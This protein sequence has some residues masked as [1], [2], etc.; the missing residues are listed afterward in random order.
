MTARA[1]SKYGPARRAAAG[2]ALAWLA[3]GACERPPAAS[4]DARPLVVTTTTMITDL[5]RQLAGDRVRVVGVIPPGMNPHT[6]E[7]TP[8]TSVLFRKA[9]LVLYN[10][11]HLEGKLVHMFAGLG[12]RA[13][14]LAEDPRI[15]VRASA[16]PQGAPDPHVWW[17]VRNFMVFTEKAR[18]ALI[19]LDPEGA[20]TYRRHAARYL[21]ELE[22]L[23][24]RIRQAVQRISPERRF[25]ITSHD[26]FYYFGAAY[27]LTVDA[28]LGTSTDASPLPLRVQELA[29]LIVQHRI[30]AIFHETA[31]SASLNEMVNRVMA[32]ATKDGH[33]VVIPPEPLYSDS[34]DEPGRPAGTYLG[35]LRENTRIIV[36]ALA[37]ED[38]GPLLDGRDG[39]TTPVPTAP[40]PTATA[41]APAEAPDAD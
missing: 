23:D 28:V 18:D 9:R 40:A 34:L 15:A 10:G 2:L 37:G 22:T 12:P 20:D 3:L 7:P 32:Q 31:V 29:R 26:A 30:P 13:V 11:L 16:G 38:V 27:G 39:P 33:A 21:A 41:A 35:A 1:W 5:A 36:S 25:L 6:F 24:G 4:A 19:A 17:D 8:D 14:A